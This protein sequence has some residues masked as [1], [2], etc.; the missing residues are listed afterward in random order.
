M[1]VLLI[2]MQTHYS[3]GIIGRIVFN[4]IVAALLI[5]IIIIIIIIY[6]LC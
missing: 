1:L 6:R 3:L 5:I 2:S 4:N